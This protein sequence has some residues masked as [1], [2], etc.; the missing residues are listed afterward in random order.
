MEILAKY[1]PEMLELF[2]RNK[3]GFKLETDNHKLIS[4]E[5]LIEETNPAN[6]H[7]TQMRANAKDFDHK[8]RG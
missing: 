1:I 7:E 8:M 6:F 2:P 5:T 4:I 3:L